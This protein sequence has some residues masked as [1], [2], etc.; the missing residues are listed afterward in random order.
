MND[1][2]GM[3]QT[4][5]LL[6]GTSEIGLEILRQLAPRR[7]EAAV[8]AGRDPASLRAAADELQ[9]AGVSQVEILDWDASDAASSTGL[10]ERARTILGD[11]D[12]VV[13]AAGNLGTAELSELDAGRVFEMMA[14]NVAGPAA[15]LLDLST[16]L[17]AQGAGQIV[18]LSSVA[19]VR[20]RRANFVYGAGKAGLDGFSLGLAEALRGSGVG[21]SVVRPGFVRT[22]MTKGREEAPFSVDA[23]EVA[24]A[25]VQG[26]EL[27]SAVVYVP[28]L[29]RYVVAVFKLLPTAVWRRLPG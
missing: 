23:A 13:V 5:L 17:A 28:S 22:K 9:S 16:A 29:L 8:L 15:A 21:V 26:L 7:L 18:V 4:A 25:V 10:G 3:P 24:T 2:T 14:V 20:V 6:G 19:G 11:I 27:S 12:L 1:A